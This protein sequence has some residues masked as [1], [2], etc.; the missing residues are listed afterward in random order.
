MQRVGSRNRNRAHPS[1]PRVP[2]RP[3]TSASRALTLKGFLTTLTLPRE[4]VVTVRGPT[5]RAQP[6]FTRFSLTGFLSFLPNFLSHFRIYSGLGTLGTAHGHLDPPLRSPTSLI[7]HR[8]V[9]E[10]SVPTPFF[11]SCRD[12]HLSG[13]FTRSLKPSLATLKA[14]SPTLL[15]AHRG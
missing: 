1:S 2:F 14:T 10:A 8:A 9:T 13:P 7:S 12:C 4:E 11:P 5:N 3:T 15:L 6:S